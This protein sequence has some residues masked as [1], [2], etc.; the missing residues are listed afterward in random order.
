VGSPVLPCT[1]WGGHGSRGDESVCECESGV[2]VI[3]EHCLTVSLSHSLTHSLTVSLTDHYSLVQQLTLW[4]YCKYQLPTNKQLTS[5]EC[6]TDSRHTH[7]LTHS[8]SH[9]HTF[10]QEGH[11]K[12]KKGSRPATSINSDINFYI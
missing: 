11:E 4:H 10:T 6:H 1:H 5:H 7:T 2:D 3:M 9:S 8:L 12:T